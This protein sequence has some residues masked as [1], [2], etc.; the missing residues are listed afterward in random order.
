[1]IRSGEN[2]FLPISPPPEGG[3]GGS[4]E[5]DFHGETRLNQTQA[6]TTDP[7]ERLFRQGKGREAKLCFMGQVPMENRHGPIITPRLTAA[8]GAA[9]RDTAEHLGKGVEEI[10]G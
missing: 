4:P 5:V 6:S 1:V 3:S 9:E 2:L 7:G 8:S 10:C